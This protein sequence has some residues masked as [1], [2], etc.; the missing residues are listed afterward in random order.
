M[1]SSLGLLRHPE[2]INKVGAHT[3]KMGGIEVH[4]VRPAR[5]IGP[6]GQ[7]RVHL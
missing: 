4:S 7:S 2:T 3:G 1:K 5:R 6:D